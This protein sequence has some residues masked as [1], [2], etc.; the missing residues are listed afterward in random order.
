MLNRVAASTTHTS[1]IIISSSNIVIAIFVTF[2][3]VII[4]YAS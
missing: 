3:P 4:A 2:V 1:V